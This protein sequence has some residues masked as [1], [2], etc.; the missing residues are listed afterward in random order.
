MAEK[1]HHVE[2]LQLLRHH[3][4]DPLL[5]RKRLFLQLKDSPEGLFLLGELAGEI[6]ALV[7]FLCDDFLALKKPE[8]NNGE[9]KRE[10]E[11]ERRFFQ[12]AKALPLDLQM[13]LCNRVAGSAGMVIRRENS[14]RGFREAAKSVFG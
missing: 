10:R 5:A 6:F 2:I 9:L 8:E 12:V 14:E 1:N 3:E 4:E 11:R 7:V 13:V